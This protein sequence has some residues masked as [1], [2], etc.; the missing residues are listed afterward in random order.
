MGAIH[1]FHTNVAHKKH[2]KRDFRGISKVIV[3]AIYSLTF[4]LA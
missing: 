1:K 3:I 2:L 4:Y